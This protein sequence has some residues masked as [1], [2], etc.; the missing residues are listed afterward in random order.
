M[1][2]T[3][4]PVN[5]IT[6]EGLPVLFIKDLPPESSVSLEVK[7]PEIYYGEITNSW[8]FSNT[9]QKEFDY[10]S[11]DE[12]VYT[13]YQGDGGV[14]VG[15]MPRRM[16]LAAY[17]RS[18]KVLLSS[19]IHA[20]SRAMYFRNIRVRARQVLPF[21]SFD[22]DPYLVVND[23]G[24]LKWIMDA[25]T[26]T[27]KYPYAERLSNGVNYMRNSVKVVID[28]Y[29]GT[30]THYL[31]DPDDPLIQTL[32]RAFPGIFHS[33][34]EMPEDLRAH[35]RYPE[36]LFRIQSDLYATYHMDEPDA[37]YHR[38]DQWQKPSLPMDGGTRDAFLRHIIMRLPGEEE[39]EFIF[40]VPFTPRG[41]DN[42]ASWMVARNDGEHYGQLVVYRLPKQSL[43][44]GP[45]QIINR[46]NQDTEISRQVSLWDQRGSQVIRGHLLVIPIEESLIYVQPVYLRAEGGRIPE[47]KRVV[48]AHQNQVVMEERLEDGLS[49]LFGDGFAE[50]VASSAESGEP[51]AQT[52]A[53]PDL[54]RRA[55]NT[56]QRA[57]EAQRAG[58]WT[59]YGEE[60]NRLG[61]ILRQME[62]PR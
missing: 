38:E 36:T 44:F 56:Y 40:M 19:D 46:I 48:V 27:R 32:S 13:S 6:S 9:G 61:E 34:D 3:L 47:L 2:L 37:F 20:D 45:T 33:L 5:Q 62:S 25:Y 58:D 53:T 51:A 29:D 22:N 39:A 12:N 60:I 55:L 14:R 59:R 28:A 23:A 54:T 50:L 41:K 21:L 15:S 1:G 17:F 8:V 18:L 35:L 42:L 52:S 26:G 4:G 49:R 16:L 43:V 24:E 11:G 57:L 31:A 30:V 7:R 10:P